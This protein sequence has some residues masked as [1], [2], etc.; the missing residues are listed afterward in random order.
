MNVEKIIQSIEKER[1]KAELEIRSVDGMARLQE[2]AEQYQGEYKLIWSHDLAEKIKN[3][4]KKTIYKTGVG[5][6]D[7]IIGGFK[8]QQLITLSAH[9]K[10][11]KTSFGI[12]LQEKMKEL[13]PIMIPLE[14]SNEEIVEQRLDNGYIL[15]MFLSPEKLAAK[16]TVN[17]IEERI[18]EGI[19]KYNT[20][21]VLIDHLGYID[22]F[23]SGE[24]YKRENTAYR[25]GQVMKD[26]KNIA[27]QW[28]VVIVLLVHISQKNEQQPPSIEDIKNS[29]DIAQESDMVIML[30]RKNYKKNKITIYEDET[31]VSVMAN[32]RTGKNGNVGLKFNRDSGLYE[33]DNSWVSQMEKEA[34]R[35]EE[36]EEF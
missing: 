19:A 3:R 5:S 6:L 27:K 35:Q 24:K 28:N 4:P 13:N 15:P 1:K 25:I 33:E 34:R 31:L 21:F 30:W 7:E 11:G 9:T 8:E 23:G 22:D 32:R 12:F 10:H 17:W 26:L 2:V 14:Q 18:I 36:V 20:K 16:V 29:S